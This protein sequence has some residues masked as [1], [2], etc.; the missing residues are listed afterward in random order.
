MTVVIFPGNTRLDVWGNQATMGP[1]EAAR[2]NGPA[3]ATAADGVTCP[4]LSELLRSQAREQHS[5]TR[6]TVHQ[7]TIRPGSS[8]AEPL[9][10]E[11][12]L[13]HG[14]KWVWRGC[15]CISNISA[16]RGKCG[17]VPFDENTLCRL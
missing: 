17:S 3:H 6:I 15:I 16:P 2:C 5:E 14:D 13:I 8:P 11:L 12:S 4:N 10:S 9:P 1:H 7:D